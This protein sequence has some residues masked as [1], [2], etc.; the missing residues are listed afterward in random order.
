MKVTFN[1]TEIELEFANYQ[2]NNNVYIGAN[3]VETG[4]P[5]MD[6]SVNTNVKLADDE[7]GIK[8][9]SENEGILDV[10]VAAEIV[11]NPIRTIPSG[12]INVQVCKLLKRN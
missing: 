1:D 9:Y 12:H 11:S 6:V 7:V 8:N 5:F 4:E 2:N 3:E 10:L